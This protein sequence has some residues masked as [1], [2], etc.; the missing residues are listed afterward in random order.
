MNQEGHRPRPRE[1]G[2]SLIEIL[3][4]V[5]IIAVMA[6]VGLPGILTYVRNYRI[7]GAERAVSSDI[8]ATRTRAITRNTQAGVS[9]LAVDG[10]TYRFV[11]EDTA[12][13]TYGELHDLP[14]GVVFDPNPPGGATNRKYFRF[15]RLGAWCD[16]IN[17]VLTCN[18]L[19]PGFPACP[20]VRCT[21]VNPGVNYIFSVA[22]G[23]TVGLLET[24]TG[25]RRAIFIDAG[26]R[27]RS[28]PQ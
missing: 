24:N 18:D 16:P 25:L 20:E 23:S 1:R 7:N 6:A 3:A 19:G 21:D 12:P 10:N 28:L 11:V 17:G 13:P 26:G 9:F 27:I 15:N 4:V 5:G 22:G 8:A 14:T 2:F